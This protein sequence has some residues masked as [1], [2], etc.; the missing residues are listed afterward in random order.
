MQVTPWLLVPRAALRGSATACSRTA[1][2]PAA[3]DPYGSQEFLGPQ[4]Y[5]A[6]LG[7]ALVRNS[8]LQGITVP[9]LTPSELVLLQ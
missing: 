3:E 4:P 7:E 8:T 6:L 9:P 5:M 2:H 1:A